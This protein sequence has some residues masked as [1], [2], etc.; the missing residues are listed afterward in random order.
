MHFF[1]RF[2]KFS[3]T[4]FIYSALILKQLVSIR[5]FVS[6][7]RI[8]VSIHGPFLKKA[9]KKMWKGFKS[10]FKTLTH[11]SSQV[12]VKYVY[13]RMARALQAGAPSCW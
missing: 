6:S 2:L 11:F 8:Q 7:A 9:R 13:L 1:I 3:I 12:D 10:G 4:L 5:S